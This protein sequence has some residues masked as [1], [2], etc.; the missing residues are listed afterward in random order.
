MAIS[1]QQLDLRPWLQNDRPDAIDIAA[2]TTPQAVAKVLPQNQPQTPTHFVVNLARLQTSP[3]GA[4]SNIKLDVNWDGRSRLSGQGDGRTINGSA[5]AVAFA[6][7][8]IKPA[9]GKE[10]AGDDGYSLFAVRTTDFG[11]ALRTFSGIPNLYGGT[12]LVEGAYHAG[13]IDASVRGQKI[14]LKQIPV[15]AQLLTVASLTGLNDTLTGEGIGFDDFDFPIR[16]RDN[17]IFVRNGWAKGRALGVNVWGT[18]DFD[19]KTLSLNGTLIPAYRFNALFGDVT[20]NG[21]GLVGIKY[22]VKGGFKLPQVGVNPLSIMM[23]GFMKVWENDQRKDA[24]A[25]LDLP[26]PKDTVNQ[27]REKTA[28]RLK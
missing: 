27:L 5:I 1:G 15:L 4:F 14:R 2:A 16:Y 26:A 23:P 6:G 7:Q 12:A 8:D 21:L 3:A 25:P 20:T 9:A 22:D 18:T 13:Q 11:D 28:D 24:I 10:K 17:R 19:H